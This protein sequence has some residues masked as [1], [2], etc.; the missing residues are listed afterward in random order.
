M[1]QSIN[2]SINF[3]LYKIF[4]HAAFSLNFSKAATVLHVTQSAVSQAIKSLETQL[5]I[6]LFYRQGRNITLTYEGEV[7]F[8]HIEK[9]F[10]FI[11]S[12]ENAMQSIKSLDEG[13]VFIGASDTITRFFLIDSIKAFHTE[14]P[15][16]KMSINNRPSPRSVEK[17]ASGELDIA[18]INVLP[19]LPYD[20]LEL[21]PWTSLE[22]VFISKYPLSNKTVSLKELSKFPLVCLESNSTTRKVLDQFLADHETLWRPAFE[23]GSFDVILEAVKA[24]MG[25]GFVPLKI[26]QTHLQSGD[27]DLIKVTE[28]TPSIEIGLLTNKSK[29]LSIAAQKYLEILKNCEV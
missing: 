4:Y 5:G 2:H 20:G 27:F 15:R 1:N 7:L 29:P 13:T 18:V 16:V 6:T 9:A 10:N 12:A 28:K 11:K 8:Q 3:E 24:G 26:A 22:H 17:L 14:Y 19:N 21:H 25:I 23:F